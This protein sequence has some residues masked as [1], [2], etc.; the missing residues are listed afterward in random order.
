MRVIK[1][2]Y[3]NAGDFTYLRLLENGPLDIKKIQERLDRFC[4]T[5]GLSILINA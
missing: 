1:G 5:K 3:F 2:F 4:F